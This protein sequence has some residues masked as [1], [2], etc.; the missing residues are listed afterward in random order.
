MLV[1][2]HFTSLVTKKFYLFPD[3][4][5]PVSENK[6]TQSV[7]VSIH[8]PT[9]KKH[10]TNLYIQSSV[11]KY[12]I[13]RKCHQKA[14]TYNIKTSREIIHH[15][16]NTLSKC[17]SEVL[18]RINL[19]CQDRKKQKQ[20]IHISTFFAYKRINLNCEY[21]IKKITILLFGGL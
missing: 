21:A 17:F 2:I 5:V 16:Y 9:W 11:N 18:S 14:F 4:M 1:F 6:S 20:N 19:Q 15:I 10:V 7:F 8:F 12:Q 13:P 3:N